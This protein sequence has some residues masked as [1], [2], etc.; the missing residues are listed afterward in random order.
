MSDLLDLF[1]DEPEPP[2]QPPVPSDPVEKSDTSPERVEETAKTEQVACALPWRQD[3]RS[4]RCR[5]GGGLACYSDD[6]ERTWFC[7][8][9]RPPNFP[10]GHLGITGQ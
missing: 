6:G 5:I 4:H 7:R 9:H 2:A 1:D 10:G 3:G 8:T